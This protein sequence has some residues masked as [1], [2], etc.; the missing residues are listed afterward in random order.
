M[1]AIDFYIL[2]R[3]FI[4]FRLFL[5]PR[6]IFDVLGRGFRCERGENYLPILPCTVPPGLFVITKIGPQIT[7][8]IGP[9]I[10][11]IIGPQITQII[12]DQEL[13]I[14]RI[15]SFLPNFLQENGAFARISLYSQQSHRERR[16]SPVLF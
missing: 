14:E 11:Q 1:E 3:A 6:P 5:K 8:I 15:I 4:R 10:T 12:A 9:Q 16:V 13:I 2:I 7:Q